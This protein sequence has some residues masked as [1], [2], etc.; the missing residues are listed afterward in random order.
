MKMNQT[1][2]NAGKLRRRYGD[3]LPVIFFDHTK[4]F[5]SEESHSSQLLGIV[6]S[7]R[8]IQQ[9]CEFV[10]NLLRQIYENQIRKR[11]K[12]IITLF[13]GFLVYNLTK[14]LLV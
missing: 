12:I 13:S 7:Q 8:L 3:R 1:E 5:G 4:R 14:A 11:L 10:Y 9:F 6:G 2:T